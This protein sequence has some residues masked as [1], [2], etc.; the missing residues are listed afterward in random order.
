MRELI[1]SSST[2]TTTSARALSLVSISRSA[3]FTR[4][5]ESRRMMAFKRSLAASFLASTSVRS[6]V[7]T[8]LTSALL[9]KKVWITRS[10]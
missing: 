1:C 7:I 8:S 5:I 6:I 4:S 10:S 2:S 9:K 3:T